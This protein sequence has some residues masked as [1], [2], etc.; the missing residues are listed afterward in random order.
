MAWFN[1][2]LAGELLCLLLAAPALY[3]P[4]WFPVWAPWTSLALL[5]GGWL[6]RRWRLGV[7]LARTPADWPLFFL[8]GVML[9]VSLWA[10]PPGLREEYSIP[11][12]YILVWNFSLFWLVV[13]HGSRRVA[14]WLLLT[15]AFLGTGMALALVAPLGVQWPDK[16]PVLGALLQRM[17][18]PLAGVF[19]GAESGFSA[20][21]VAGVLLFVLPLVIVLVGASFA[22][23]KRSPVWWAAAL[24]ATGM[25][26]VLVAT[27]SRSGMIGLA[28]GMVVAILLPFRWGRWL[29]AGGAVATALLLWFQFDR[30]L[31]LSDAVLSNDIGEQ[32]GTLLWRGDVWAR[33]LD[34]IQDFRFT[35]MGLGTFRESVDIYPPFLAGPQYDLAHAH[36]FFMQQALDFGLPGFIALVAIYMVVVGQIVAL[37]RAAVHPEVPAGPIVSWRNWALGFAAS[38]AAQTV[39]SLTDAVT[40][41]AKPNFLLWYLLALI[42][43][44]ANFVH[45]ASLYHRQTEQHTRT[46]G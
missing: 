16:T 30:I 25:A 14:T 1:P 20:N 11:R 28:A 12:T 18:T 29:L 4:N 22:R 13:T 42:F 31:L 6:W 15:A 5:A 26:V 8:F 44:A 10:A 36:N 35:G 27:Q 45:H 7:W 40:M 3:F 37:W 33:A 39:Y 17:P 23:C 34:A 32:A 9:P 19:R 43:G 2:T 24:A 38:L 41:G 46:F 21:Q